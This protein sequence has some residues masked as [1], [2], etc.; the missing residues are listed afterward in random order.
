MLTLKLPTGF[1]PKMGTELLGP[2]KLKQFW[3]CVEA[4]FQMWGNFPGGSI[5]I[6]IVR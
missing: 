1:K 6:Y 5:G 3:E 4:D 2:G